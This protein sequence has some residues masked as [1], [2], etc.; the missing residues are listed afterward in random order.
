MLSVPHMIVVFIIVLV[1]FGPN[2]LP[3]LARGLGKL[4]AEF[5]KASADFKGAFEQEMRDLERQTMLAERKKAAEA[6][7]AS[8]AAAAPAPPATLA[9]PAGTDTQP[10]V[11]ADT[12]ATEG[13]LATPAVATVARGHAEESPVP[14]EQTASASE[15]GLSRSENTIGN[16]H[17]V[18]DSQPET[19]ATAAAHDPAHDS[20]QPA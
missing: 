13:L 1:V 7:A 17:A 16:G 12:R 11:S 18:L 4:M 8:A 6:A 20:Q 14:V 10:G 5:R 19:P 15:D 2:K 9:T 3:E